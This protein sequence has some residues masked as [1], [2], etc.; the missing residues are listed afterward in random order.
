MTFFSR[1]I[2]IL[3]LLHIVHSLDNGLAPTPVMGWLGWERFKCNVDCEN[4]P[5]NC[6]HEGLFREIANRMVSD[7]YVD[8]GY[9]YINL[10]DCWMGIL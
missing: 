7:G 5:K 4:D 6:I 9:K 3:A 2:I 8:A 1:Y 10:D